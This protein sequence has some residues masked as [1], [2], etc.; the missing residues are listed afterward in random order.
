MISRQKYNICVTSLKCHPQK[1]VDLENVAF[2]IKE[3]QLMLVL[4]ALYNVMNV[5]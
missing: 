3:L 5:K 4:N 2:L 1:P